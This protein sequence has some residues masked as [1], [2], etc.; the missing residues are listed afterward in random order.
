M[1]QFYGERANTWDV[2]SALGHPEHMQSPGWWLTRAVTDLS[3]GCRYRH[4]SCNLFWR[5]LPL[6]I[7]DLE[8]TLPRVVQANSFLIQSSPPQ[9]PFLILP[10][11]PTCSNLLSASHFAALLSWKLLS[12]SETPLFA[13][14]MLVHF[15]MAWP[16]AVRTPEIRAVALRVHCYVISLKCLLWTCW[17][18]V[19]IFKEINIHLGYNQ[20]VINNTFPDTGEWPHW[21][22]EIIRGHL[23]G[24]EN[25][26]WEFLAGELDKFSVQRQMLLVP[27][28]SQEISLNSRS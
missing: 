11:W 20:R 9:Q 28:I 16:L 7:Y 5:V 12:L 15:S 26:L 18:S 14:L 22:T 13:G 3:A 23:R 17:H 25:L 4:P 10:I 19:N 1:L 6:L 27:S 8:R 2:I 21:V 24:G